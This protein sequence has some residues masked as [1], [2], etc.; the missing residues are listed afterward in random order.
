MVDKPAGIPV[1]PTRLF[2]EHS[3]LHLLRAKTKNKNLSPL[4]RLDQETSGLTAF[5]KKPKARGFYQ[6]QFQQKKVTKVYLA[7]VFGHV[8]PELTSIDL[9][10]G[11]HDQIYT[12][13][14]PDPTGKPAKTKVE[15]VVHEGEYSLL[16]LRPVTGRTHTRQMGT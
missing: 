9:P 2:F 16:R 6:R 7:M 13:F 8:D 12:R 3:L 1:T 15:K 4:H 14:I 10:L 11:R 5:A